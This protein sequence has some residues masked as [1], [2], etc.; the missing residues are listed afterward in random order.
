MTVLERM[1]KLDKIILNLLTNPIVEIGTDSAGWN[2]RK[3]ANGDYEAYKDVEVSGSTAAL[4]PTAPMN[5]FG[6]LNI[7]AQSTPSGVTVNATS[8][9]LLKTTGWGWLI[10][11][12]SSTF[13]SDYRFV[14]FLVTSGTYKLTIR[15]TCTGKWK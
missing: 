6:Y 8:A 1:K 12:A 2:F 11:M 10:R 14:T 5:N 4:S 9:E 13:S 7:N 15:W 3:Y